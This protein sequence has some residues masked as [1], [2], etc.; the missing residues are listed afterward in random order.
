M[1][2]GGQVHDGPQIGPEPGG[3]LARKTPHDGAAGRLAGRTGEFGQ[4]DHCREQPEGVDENQHRHGDGLRGQGQHV[5]LTRSA[6]VGDPAD[7][8]PGQQSHQG[9]QAHA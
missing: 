9:A 3:L 8:D 5:D 4:A 7:R 6:P 2:D 1:L